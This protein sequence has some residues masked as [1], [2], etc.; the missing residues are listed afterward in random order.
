MTPSPGPAV[1]PSGP[2][3]VPS[4]PGPR[5][6]S[7]CPHGVGGGP[8]TASDLVSHPGKA[9]S[10]VLAEPVNSL[11]PVACFMRSWDV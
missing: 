3:P 4:G 6:V 8:G 7:D 1:I 9:L 5:N 10:P 2:S 11:R